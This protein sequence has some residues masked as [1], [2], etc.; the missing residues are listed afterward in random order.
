[1]WTQLGSG[2]GNLCVRGFGYTGLGSSVSFPCESAGFSH[3][4]GCESGGCVWMSVRG[5]VKVY[6]CICVFVLVCRC[7]CVCMCEINN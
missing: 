5:C 2:L 4:C 1:M 6:D 3:E 7:V